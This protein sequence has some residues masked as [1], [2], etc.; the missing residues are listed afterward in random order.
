MI[1]RVSADQRNYSVLRNQRT[2]S[3]LPADNSYSSE[4]HAVNM[5]RVSVLRVSTDPKSHSD[6]KSQRAHTHKTENVNHER[7][8]HCSA[9]RAAD[10]P[11]QHDPIHCKRIEQCDAV[12]LKEF[13]DHM[14]LCSVCLQ[15][16]HDELDCNRRRNRCTQ[17]IFPHTELLP[18]TEVLPL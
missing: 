1:N 6:Q 15:P 12:Y 9:C 18:H 8:H 11:F 4:S 14:S 17:C 13:V 16:G 10:K 5:G 3:P 2:G 7:R